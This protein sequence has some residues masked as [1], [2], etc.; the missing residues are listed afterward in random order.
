MVAALAG[1]RGCRAR[2]D[3]L[4]AR[5]NGGV[6]GGLGDGRLVVPSGG[7]SGRGAKGVWGGGKGGLV[8]FMWHVDCVGVMAPTN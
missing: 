1:R 4:E 2:M 6:E 7:Q 3:I 5:Q 8:Q